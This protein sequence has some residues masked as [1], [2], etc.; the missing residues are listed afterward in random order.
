MGSREAEFRPT[1]IWE[2]SD[3]LY[4]RRDETTDT[5]ENN[6]IFGSLEIDRKPMLQQGWEVF[7]KNFMAVKSVKF[8]W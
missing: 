2:R 8:L 6:R 1:E 4:E 5:T 7:L 3:P